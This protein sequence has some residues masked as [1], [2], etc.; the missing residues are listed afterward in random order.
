MQ[1]SEYKIKHN[2]QPINYY[3]ENKFGID[4]V[5]AYINVTNSQIIIVVFIDKKTI[6]LW[7]VR[8]SNEMFKMQ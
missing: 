8:A 4:L 2:C 7:I 6:H 1:N 5:K 3:Q